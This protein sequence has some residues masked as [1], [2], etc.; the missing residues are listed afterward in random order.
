MYIMLRN[1]RNFKEMSTCQYTKYLSVLLG[2]SSIPEGRSEGK[3]WE[4]KGIGRAAARSALRVSREMLWAQVW[5]AAE[6]DPSPSSDWAGLVPSA[7]T[8]PPHYTPLP[9][10]CESFVFHISDLYHTHTDRHAPK[11]QRKG[12]D[13]TT[14]LLKCSKAAKLK[15]SLLH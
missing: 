2:P 11:M 10:P 3:S 8:G 4:G 12:Q 7:N 9:F 6:E 5:T 1:G 13:E 15:L 14:N